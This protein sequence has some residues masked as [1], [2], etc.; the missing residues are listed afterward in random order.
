MKPAIY[1]ASA[2]TVERHVV[3]GRKVHVL[4]DQA[5]VRRCRT[6]RRA[7]KEDHRRLLQIEKAAQQHDCENNGCDAAGHIPIQTLVGRLI[8]GLPSAAGLQSLRIN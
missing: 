7:R 4:V 1:H 2:K 3:G 8:T 6:Q 5:P